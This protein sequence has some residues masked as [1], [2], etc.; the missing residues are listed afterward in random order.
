MLG[1]TR[2]S[3][4]PKALARWVGV[5]RTAAVLGCV[6]AL[7]ACS[8]THVGTNP[9]DQL[10]TGVGGATPTGV[11]GSAG[12]STGGA[13]T[14]VAGGGADFGVREGDP[15]CELMQ[16]AAP[17]F[18]AQVFDP[19]RPARA[20]LFT[21]TSDEQAVSLRRDRVL[22][23]EAETDFGDVASPAHTLQAI[24]ATAGADQAQLATAL[25]A[26]F[27]KRR[28]AW[29]EPWAMRLGWPGEERGHQLLRVVLK[30]EAWIAIVRQ[31]S[32]T[33]VDLY[34]QVVLTSDANATPERIGALYYEHDE[35]AG[36]PQCPGSFGGPGYREFVIGNLAMVQEWS[37]GTQLIADRL[38]SN[39]DQL[40]QFLPH[41]RSC[42]ARMDASQFNTSSACSWDQPEQ[43]AYNDTYAYVRALAVP[44]ANYLV[45]PEPIAT[46]IDTLREDS[47]EPDPVVVTS[48]GLP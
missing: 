3:G 42:P 36:G 35:L 22:F 39:I 1:G 43:G 44:S 46:L 10:S 20:E 16:S 38:V 40:T 31:Q 15:Q 45:Q 47:F 13:A 2:V 21:W 48:G 41:V 24:A 11:I 18:V 5:R 30:N 4:L 19:S 26:S 33:V 9:D 23:T 8:S 32:L 6:A 14:G 37:L 29:P 34:N 28:Y 27:A 17:V 25:D 7:A 12:A